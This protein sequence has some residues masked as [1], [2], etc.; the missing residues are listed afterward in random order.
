M[1]IIIC[2]QTS[3]NHW[4]KAYIKFDIKSEQA[5]LIM[6][7]FWWCYQIEILHERVFKNFE[8][9]PIKLHRMYFTLRHPFVSIVHGFHLRQYH[10]VNTQ[11]VHYPIIWL[12]HTVP[13][14]FTWKNLIFSRVNILTY[15]LAYHFN[16]SITLT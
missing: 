1:S 13:H 2:I 6:V 8:Y 16:L 14:F 15:N 4:F 7:S 5:A 9:G 12:S 3:H 11:T 10:A